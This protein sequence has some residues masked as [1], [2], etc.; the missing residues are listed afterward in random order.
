MSVHY[1]KAAMIY[2][3][4]GVIEVTKQFVKKVCPKYFHLDEAEHFDDSV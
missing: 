4:Y 2:V 1:E 3:T